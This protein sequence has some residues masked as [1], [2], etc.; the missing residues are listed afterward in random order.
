MQFNTG[1]VHWKFGVKAQRNSIEQVNEKRHNV[2]CGHRL[3]YTA[4]L[5]RSK[6]YDLNRK[7]IC[8]KLVVLDFHGYYFLANERYLK[9]RMFE[10]GEFHVITT[11][12]IMCC[13]A[14]SNEYKISFL[15]NP[16]SSCHYS[17]RMNKYGYYIMWGS[18]ISDNSVLNWNT[19]P[20]C[21]NRAP[22][23]REC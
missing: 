15:W 3:M 16:S 20:E 18:V 5:L 12:Q 6:P 21:K 11:L 8:V 17:W 7:N 14:C 1:W 9:T 22:L 23:A 4:A 19:P 13:M 10:K 2:F